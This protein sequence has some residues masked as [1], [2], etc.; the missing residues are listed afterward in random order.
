M[1]SNRILSFAGTARAGK[2]IG[3]AGQPGRT[4]LGANRLIPSSEHSFTV[5]T[6]WFR[7]L[8]VFFVI[9]HDTR[10]IVHARVIAHPNSQWLAQQMIEACG[11]S[12]EPPRFLIHD[13]D[14]SFGTAFD[15]RVQSMATASKY[16]PKSTQSRALALTERINRKTHCNISAR[17]VALRLSVGC[18]VIRTEFLRPTTNLQT[19]Q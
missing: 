1:W 17:R 11:L 19:T 13:R 3:D 2:P 12:A 10:K 16:G 8:Y 7:T 6:V 18:L 14:S 9:H 15:R 4:N 5:Q